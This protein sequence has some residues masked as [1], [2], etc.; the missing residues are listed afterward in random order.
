M[1]SYWMNS[2]DKAVAGKKLDDDMD[3]YWAKKEDKK[4]GEGEEAPAAEEEEAKE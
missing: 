4:E 1:D 2:K 3:A